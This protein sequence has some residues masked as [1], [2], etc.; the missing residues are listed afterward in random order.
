LGRRWEPRKGKKRH[1]RAG[2]RWPS[3]AGL[4]VKLRSAKLALPRPER[5]RRDRPGGGTPDRPLTPTAGMTA[6]K[7]K[8]TPA[9]SVGVVNLLAHVEHAG[10]PQFPARFGVR[11]LLR[12]ARGPVDERQGP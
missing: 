4:R 7:A 3:R 1:P 11:F 10:N 12:P 8:S 6:M 5:P 2:S 9:V